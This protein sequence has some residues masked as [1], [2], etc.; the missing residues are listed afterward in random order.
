MWSALWP[1]ILPVAFFLDHWSVLKIV[2]RTTP[3]VYPLMLR[4]SIR[5]AITVFISSFGA[6]LAVCGILRLRK[7]KPRIWPRAGLDLAF[8]G[9]LVV[10]P[11]ITAVGIDPARRPSLLDLWIDHPSQAS[12]IPDVC[13]V[14]AALTFL[15][16]SRE[17][18][19]LG[20][21]A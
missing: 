18:R 21:P 9:V 15:F 4:L 19:R 20:A 13:A 12:A 8:L 14:L 1:L 7:L 17:K 6:G 5:A 10:V 2:E 3:V 16:A 11:W